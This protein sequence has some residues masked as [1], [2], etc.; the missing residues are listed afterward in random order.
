MTSYI[1]LSNNNYIKSNN[2]LNEKYEIL[3]NM[4]QPI[5]INYNYNEYELK[6]IFFQPNNNSPPN[7]FMENLTKRINYY[8]T[9]EYNYDDKNED[10][11]DIQ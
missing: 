7:Q 3:I 1:S 8:Y 5:K 10:I 6:E 2:K 4:T 9:N 11:F